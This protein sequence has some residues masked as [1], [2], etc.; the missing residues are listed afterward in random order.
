[1]TDGVHHGQNNFMLKLKLNLTKSTKTLPNKNK[2]CSKIRVCV[3]LEDRRSSHTTL[4]RDFTSIILKNY[5]KNV[6]Y[7]LLR[8]TLCFLYCL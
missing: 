2:K 7:V 6:Q 5:P 1:M 3:W 8:G 4:I